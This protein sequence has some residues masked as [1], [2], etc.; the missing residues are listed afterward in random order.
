MPGGVKGQSNHF[1]I[2]LTH[3]V[4]FMGWQCP[5][6]VWFRFQSEDW[7]KDKGAAAYEAGALPFQSG[8]LQP[9]TPSEIA[10]GTNQNNSAW[11]WVV[12]ETPSLLETTALEAAQN[13]FNIDLR[14]NTAKVDPVKNPVRSESDKKTWAPRPPSHHRPGKPG[15]LAPRSSASCCLSAIS[16]RYQK[17]RP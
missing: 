16:P 12:Y 9:K 2:E 17:G 14:L 7:S 1:A 11:S 3:Y 8:P 6:N 5:L 10:N 4:T 13:Y 15:S